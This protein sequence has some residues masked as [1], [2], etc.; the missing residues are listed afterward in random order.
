MGTTIVT[1]SGTLKA[2]L[3]DA[4]R[5]GGALVIWVESL[6]YQGVRIIGQEGIHAKESVLLPLMLT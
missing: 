4:C 6:G 1:G 5:G 2:T 3:I